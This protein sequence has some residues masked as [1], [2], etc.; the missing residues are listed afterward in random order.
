MDIPWSEVKV[1]RA[2]VFPETGN[3]HPAVWLNQIEGESSLPIQ[4]GQNEALAISSG[5]QDEPTQRPSTNDLFSNLLNQ[6][7][8]EIDEVRITELKDTI[9][10]AEILISAKGEQIRLDARPSDGIVLALKRGAKIRVAQQ[11]F[12]E[13]GI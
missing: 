11:V 7:D 6:I 12:K 3:P 8:G 10:Y 4:I 13:A 5:L 9:F 1:D 2:G